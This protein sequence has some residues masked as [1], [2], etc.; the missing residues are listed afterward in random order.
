METEPSFPY[1]GPYIP[2]D[3]KKEK[4]NL[5]KQRGSQNFSF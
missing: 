4:I 1:D 5:L 2:K 3:Q